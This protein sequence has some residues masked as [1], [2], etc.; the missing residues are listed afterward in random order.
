[1]MKITNVGANG[2]GSASHLAVQPFSSTEILTAMQNGSGNLE[3]IG[4]VY[5]NGDLTRAASPT[6]GTAQEVALALLGRKAVTAVRSGSD[7]LLLISWDASSGLQT[8]TRQHDTAHMA[9]EASEIAITAINNNMVVTAC[10]NGSGG[11][12]LICWGVGADGSFTRLGDSNPSGQPPQAGEVSLVTIAN[13]GNNIVVTAVKNGSDNLELIGWRIS[14]DGKTIHRQ[15]PV[16]ATAGTVGEIALTPFSDSET[17]QAGV[18]TAVQNGSGNLELIAWRVLDQGMG[19]QRL[20]DTSTLPSGQRP[21]TASHI[22]ISPSGN[23]ANTFLTTMR[24]GSGDLEL[25]A[26]SLGRNGGF[27]REGDLGQSQGTDVTETALTSFF[28]R[29]VSAT[30]KADFLNVAVWEVST[31]NKT[32]VTNTAAI[33]QWFASA[34]ADPG[35]ADKLKGDWISLMKAELPLSEH[36]KESLAL[37]P[38]HHAKELKAA[39]AMVVEK[40]GTIHLD[41]KSENSPGTLVVQPTVTGTHTAD[42]SINVFHC[43]FDANCRHWHCGW[44]PARR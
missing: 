9:G 13:V 8:I 15:N 34:L 38:E 6:A 22:S 39:I 3:L 16:G 11:L 37:I 18:I 35:R 19:F 33:N 23:A 28:G 17:G 7:N 5:N 42:L 24:R 12:L 2:A 27:T 32:Q 41:R 40:G 14:N 1:M 26:F 4:W 25:I 10:R 20:G 43:T 29:D 44:G 30:R 21:G 31:L 36:Q